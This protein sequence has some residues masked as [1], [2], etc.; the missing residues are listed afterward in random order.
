M[1]LTGNQI[2]KE[3]KE[4]RIIIYPFYK[5][6]IS[7]NSYDLALSCRLLKYTN[8]ILDPKIKQPVEEIE[9]PDGGLHL[10]AGQFRLGASIEI[11]GSDYFVP[12]IHAK[13][14]FARMGLFVHCTAD[15]IDIGSKGNITFQMFTTLPIILYPEMRIGQV[16]F[17]QPKGK[18]ELYTGK[19]QGSVGAQPSRSWRDFLKSKN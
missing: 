16:S 8:P 5:E 13:S 7:T 15:L 1:I 10:P 11:V 12:I 9:I 18:I 4:E 3:V 6:R 17:W 14:S 2:K 19:Y